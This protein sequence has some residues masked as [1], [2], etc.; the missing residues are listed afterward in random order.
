MKSL[1]A[2]FVLL[3]G[4]LCLCEARSQNVKYRKTYLQP[5]EQ[6]PNFNHSVDSA[7][8]N[9]D[10]VVLNEETEWQIND[11]QNTTIVTKRSRIKIL[12]QQ[13]AAQCSWVALPQGTDIASEYSDVP[14]MQRNY[15]HRPKYFDLDITLFHARIL[16]PNQQLKTVIPEDSV[17]TETLQYNNRTR[18]AY[19]YHFY[20]DGLQPGDILETEYS[21]FLPF[22][23]DYR[24]IFFNGNL[25]I[26]NYTLKI[27]APA[28]EYM[29]YHLANGTP[30][31][32]TLKSKQAPDYN[33]TYT[34]NLQHLAGCITE[35]GARPYA[36]LPHLVYYAHNKAYGIWQN[37]QITQ[38][39]PYTWSYFAYDLVNF[40]SLNLQKTRRRL[41]AKAI[42]LNIFFK[43]QTAGI[44]ED[45]PILRLLQIHKT[46]AHDFDY[47]TDG[48]PFANTDE[49]MA[50][51]TSGQRELILREMSKNQQFQGVFNRISDIPF[52]DVITEGYF[53]L[54]DAKPER[55]PQCLARGYLLNINRYEIYEELLT[56]L[57]ED[58]F[59][60]LVSDIRIG[61]LNPDTCLP[62][63]GGDM[64]YS[65][66][67]AGNLF[68]LYPKNR[69][70]GYELNELPFYLENTHA[71]H[72]WQMADNH[73]NPATARFFETPV[74]LAAQNYRITNSKVTVNL[75][76]QQVSFDTKLS[77]SG[78]FSTILREFYQYHSQD[79]T[80][81]ERYYR[82]VAAIS[83]NTATEEPI[84]LQHNLQYPFNAELRLKYSDNSL[85]TQVNDSVFIVNLHNWVQHVITDNFNASGRQLPFY[86]DF[87]GTD[88]YHYYLEFN[89][90]IKI[91]KFKDLPLEIGNEF[92]SYTFSIEQQSPTVV[93]IHSV[94]KIGTPRLLPQQAGM[95]AQIFNSI[96]Q[97]E[98][99]TLKVIRLQQE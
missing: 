85:I 15:V 77:L 37:D 78:Q 45:K 98:A 26:Q 54:T 74:S 11:R 40:R 62:I 31:P 39:K 2:I 29:V 1:F 90:P 14:L 60:V 18:F 59:R 30:P 91:S 21:Y 88:T 27:T 16:K 22:M 89:E 34:W 44:G 7:F 75:N 23:F 71:L 82:H 9:A 93:L 57:R 13:G 61:Q 63:F 83:V 10:A 86:P 58:Y 79:S 51:I 72:I 33:L 64:L 28:R 76:S 20:L 55:I 48:D 47:Q 52:T 56:R 73:A 36:D 35:P 99:A 42:A 68:Y 69:R 49:R 95:A 46:L 12:T 87:E 50:K 66:G 5:W 4:L 80:L 96:K 6:R 81:N 53:G 70:F 84:I 19:S 97:V 17:Q 94:F 92:G 3:L 41:S 65:V 32:D 67:T 24:R 25:P 43:T 38:F 8:A